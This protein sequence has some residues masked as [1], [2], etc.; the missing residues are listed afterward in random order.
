MFSIG[1]V[2]IFSQSAVVTLTTI[3]CLHKS[4]VPTEHQVMYGVSQTGE[5][6]LQLALPHPQPEVDF[7]SLIMILRLYFYPS[8]YETAA[9]INLAVRPSS[10][11]RFAVSVVLTIPTVLLSL[12]AQTEVISLWG[13]RALPISPMT[14]STTDMSL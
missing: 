13:I 7:T 11:H 10:L 1:L 6:P 5:M 2:T 8:K 3:L 9:L 12:A 4:T 14:I